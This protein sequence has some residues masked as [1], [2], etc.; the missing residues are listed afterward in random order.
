M[1]EKAFSFLDMPDR[2]VK[3]R[4]KGMTMCLDQGMGIN[5]IKDLLP[6]LSLIHI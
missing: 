5:Y 6:M 3:P 1:S 4:S 2:S